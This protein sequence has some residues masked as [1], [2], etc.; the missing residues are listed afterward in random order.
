MAIQVSD[1]SASNVSA[2]QRIDRRGALQSLLEGRPSLDSAS[3]DLDAL[4][5]FSAIRDRAA[6]EVRSLSLPSTRDEEWRFT[7]LSPLL[8][9]PFQA[10]QHQD[11][12]LTVAD[13]EPFFLPESYGCTLVF[14]NGHYAPQFSSA[15]PLPDGLVVTHLANPEFLA[16]Q[17]TALTSYFDKQEGVERVFTTLNTASFADAAVIWISPNVVT[18]IPIHVLFVTAPSA[19]TPSEK[20]P[21]AGLAVTPRCL[22]VA[23]R[24][25]ALTLVEDHVA[26]GEGSYFTNSVTE[27]WVEENSRINHVR[28]Q[29]DRTDAIHIGKTAVSQA[30]TSYYTCNA[31]SLGAQVSRHNLEVFQ[32]GEETDTTMNGLTLIAGEQL[33][34]TH[35]LMAYTKPYGTSRQLHKCIVDDKAHAV[36]NGK[37]NVPQ[38]AQMTN[39]NQLNRNLLLS[40]R[41]RVDTKP[42][43]EIVADNVKCTHGATVSQLES[44]EVFYLRSRGIDAEQ[45]QD[46][47]VYAFAAEILQE[48]P[49]ESLRSRLSRRIESLT[50]SKSKK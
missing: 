1:S 49:V 31:I 17:P 8:K 22:V 23:E 37:V 15:A 36:F 34:D 14:V 5:P 12:G 44:D 45:A 20:T 48:I 33:A 35:S 21:G 27:I 26:I 46:L 13:L 47:L 40:S 30:K 29:R 3:T 24:N 42:Q 7:D 25:S 18:T 41:G 4:N 10:S 11:F 39:A 28:L 16:A 50:Q 19:T 9:Q 6:E 38:A 2:S 43:L 32:G